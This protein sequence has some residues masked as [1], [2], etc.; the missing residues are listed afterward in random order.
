PYQ[1]KTDL[2]VAVGLSEKSEAPPEPF[3][4]LLTVLPVVASNP[5]QGALVGVAAILGIYLGD[6]KTT[7]ISNI[8]AN[9]LYTTKK[10]FLSPIHTVLMLSDNSRQLQSGCRG[11]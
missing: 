7:T 6:P 3:K 4:P 9:V 10:Q 11:P 5:T 8:S 2:F 1:D